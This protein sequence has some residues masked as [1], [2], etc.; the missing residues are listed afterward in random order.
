MGN[1]S[2]I[3]GNWNVTKVKL[4][5]YFDKLTDKDLVWTKGRQG[6]MLDK[7]QAKLGKTKE[8]L[9]SIISELEVGML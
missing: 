3:E 6:L 5:H 8:E 9:D 4:K 7:I 1:S 2:E